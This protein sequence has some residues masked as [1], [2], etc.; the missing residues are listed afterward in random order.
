M[1]KYYYKTGTIIFETC[2]Y[3]VTA[4]SEDEAMDKLVSRINEEFDDEYH[5]VK[6]I[7]ISLSDI[8]EVEI[9]LIEKEEKDD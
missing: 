6:Q 5:D 4:E 2:N 3:E 1:S 7:S 8:G 9:E